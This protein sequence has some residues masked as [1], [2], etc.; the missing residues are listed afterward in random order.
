MTRRGPPLTPCSVILLVVLIQVSNGRLVAGGQLR[1]YGPGQH[2]PLKRP[3][4]RCLRWRKSWRSRLLLDRLARPM[5]SP[6]RWC[7]L[8]P[9]MPQ[10]SR[11]PK[12]SSMAA[13]L[14]H[15]M[16]LQS[17][18]NR[19]FCLLVIHTVKSRNH[20]QMKNVSAIL[21]TNLLASS[22]VSSAL[23]YGQAL[24]PWKNTCGCCTCANSSHFYSKRHRAL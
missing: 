5:R 16:A 1:P 12:L 18:G 15:Q 11:L 7:S 24:R 9:M 10:I 20:E 23:R 4:Q 2:R 17:I 19:C 22:I 13:R 21:F 3:Q 6:G 14:E 8:P